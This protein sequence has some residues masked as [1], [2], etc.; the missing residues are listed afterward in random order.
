MQATI[1]V[2]YDNPPKPGKKMANVKDAAGVTYF[3]YPDK[4]G[5]QSGETVTIDYD[6]QDWGGKPMNV[7]KAIVPNGYRGP[8]QMQQQTVMAPAYT[9]APAAMSEPG[10][11]FRAGEFSNGHSN[12]AS[13][14]MLIFV[15][16]V[17]GR[18]MGSGQYSATDI[19][20]L[21]KA[22]VVAFHESFGT[23]P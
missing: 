3:Y 11:K 6:V 19:G 23:N 8:Q 2:K 7:V 13:K 17:V 4:M 9:P 22:A 16:G 12:G 1:Q 15:T 5:F 21:T 18:A 10:G 14:D 20:L